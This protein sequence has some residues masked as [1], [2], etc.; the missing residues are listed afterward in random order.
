MRGYRNKFTSKNFD[1]TF[2]LSNLGLSLDDLFHQALHN[3]E[4]KKEKKLCKDWYRCTRMIRIYIDL[5]DA[6]CPR[7]DWVKLHHDGQLCRHDYTV[8]KPLK[9]LFKPCRKCNGKGCKICDLAGYVERGKFTMHKRCKGGGCGYCD[10]VGY[11]LPGEKARDSLP[12]F[13]LKRVK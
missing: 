7:L 13:R 5:L 4:R 8:F 3:V 9:K 6:G 10:F 11:F 1:L 12:K 2:P